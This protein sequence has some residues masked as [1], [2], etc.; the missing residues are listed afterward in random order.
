M[1]LDHCKLLLLIVISIQI[2]I[3]GIKLSD[4]LDKLDKKL[5]TDIINICPE[6]PST[7]LPNV[8]L[9]TTAQALCLT[10]AY[11]KLEEVEEVP[12]VYTNK[13]ADG[14]YI[15]LVRMNGK[16]YKVSK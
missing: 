2:T 4:R 14:T 6:Y 8:Q 3:W 12:G 16:L 7:D 15:D 10:N 13:N 1:T 5:S 9:C 11:V